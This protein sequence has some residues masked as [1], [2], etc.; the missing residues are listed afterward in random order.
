MDLSSQHENSM[1]QDGPAGYT[2]SPSSEYVRVAILKPLFM[3]LIQLPTK[4]PHD[5]LFG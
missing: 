1:L 5:P 4:G 2:F 3:D